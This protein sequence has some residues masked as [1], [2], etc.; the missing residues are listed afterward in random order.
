MGVTIRC[1]VAICL[2]YT[3]CALSRDCRCVAVMT[4]A[5]RRS[6]PV[7]GKAVASVVTFPYVAVTS[8]ARQGA[9]VEQR[10]DDLVY[11]PRGW[12]GAWEV[13]PGGVEG[14]SVRWGSSL[15]Y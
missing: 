1:D 7:H 15:R 10:K 2:V 5:R 6:D 13:P 9:P 12:R 11:T 4:H 3:V 8:H 14:L